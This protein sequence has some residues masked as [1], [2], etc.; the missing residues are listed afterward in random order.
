MQVR[1]SWPEEQRQI[2]SLMPYTRI[3]AVAA[4]DDGK[5]VNYTIIFQP[6]MG[7]ESKECEGDL[8][9]GWAGHDDRGF[10]LPCKGKVVA[11][12]VSDPPQ[13][14]LGKVSSKRPPAFTVRLRSQRY[15]EEICRRDYKVIA[16]PGELLEASSTWDSDVWRVSASVREEGLLRS[17][18]KSAALCV[19]ASDGKVVFRVPVYW[20][21][22]P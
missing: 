20:E 3:E 16:Q 18:V 12:W 1:E 5:A 13:V 9:V 10:K 14:V 11:E 8:V 2:K 21:T 17:G 15:A 19:T 4:E 22:E 7:V 6:P